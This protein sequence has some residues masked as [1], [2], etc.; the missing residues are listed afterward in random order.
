MSETMGQKYT[1]GI[2]L[3]EGVGLLD[4]MGALEPFSLVED[5]SDH[6]MTTYLIAESTELVEFASANVQVKPHKSFQE[7]DKV[8]I[9]F[10][11]GSGPEP[12]AAALKNDTLL[13]YI[14]T[15]S[16]TSTW[17]TSVCSGSL[18]LAKLG[19]LD[20]FEATTHW[21]FMPCLREFPEVKIR[22]GYHRVVR[23]GNRITGGGISSSIEEALEIITIVTSEDVAK[24]VREILEYYPQISQAIP[25]TQDYCKIDDETLLCK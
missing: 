5:V 14:K 8:D 19:L 24:G 25:P 23:D 9:L 11:P 10:V 13:E 7:I 17:I 3:Y 16:T 22:D 6:T 1:V 21:E 18:L 4:V 15:L 12:T 20:G 2:P